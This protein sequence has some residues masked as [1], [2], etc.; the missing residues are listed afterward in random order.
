MAWNEPGKGRDPWGDRGDAQDIDEVLRRIQRRLQGFFGGGN[1]DANS[2]FGFLFAGIAVLAWVIG[3]GVYTVDAAE[4]GV[5]LRFGKYHRTTP[6]GLQVHFPWPFV[7]HEVVNVDAIKNYS[8]RTQMF[9]HD[10]NLVEIDM[11]VQYVIND[12][13]DYLFKIRNPALTVQDVSE[14]AIREIVGKSN[15][16]SVLEEDRPKIPRETLALIQET[17]DGYQS[18]ILI[19]SVNLQQVQFPSQVKAAADDVVKARED[20]ERFENE[21]KAYANDVVPKARG[22]AARRIQEAEAYRDRVIAE[23]EGDAER[24]LKLLT[25]YQAAPGVTR[26]RLYLETMEI[27]LGQN[28]KVILDAEGNGSLIY[29]PIDRLLEQGGARRLT[30]DSDETRYGGSDSGSSDSGASRDDVDYRTRRNRQ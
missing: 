11:V 8:H 5:E 25:E 24:F 18:G 10:E 29:L 12:V 4:R 28:A 1:G 23:A 3:T 2:L 22:R 17:L 14:S 7:T 27:V 20:K 19:S 30:E 15:L 16:E 26:E 6:P 13:E 9:T 21:A